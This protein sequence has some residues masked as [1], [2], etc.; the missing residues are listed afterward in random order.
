LFPD[1][2]TVISPFS[3]AR[4]GDSILHA[5][6]RFAEGDPLELEVTKGEIK[7]IPLEPGQEANLVITGFPRTWI[8]ERPAKTRVEIRVRGGL[9]GLVIDGR[10]RPIYLPKDDDE[11]IQIQKV[12][13]NQLGIGNKVSL[14][15]L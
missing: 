5:R 2:G 10:G 6:I 9:C 1:L 13:R 7:V 3:D 4:F 8:T 15:V 12:W 14:G 11:R